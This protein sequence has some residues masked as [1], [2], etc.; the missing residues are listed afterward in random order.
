MSL[1]T[2]TL[3]FDAHGRGVDLDIIVADLEAAASAALATG[4]KILA[5]GDIAGGTGFTVQHVDDSGSYVIEFDVEFDT[6]PAVVACHIDG[7]GERTIRCASSAGSATVL[8]CD[9]DGVEVD[10]GFSFVVV[11][12]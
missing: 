4:G 9:G 3:I 11:P 8:T 6:A 2:D 7:D 10:S 5:N 12:L 1:P